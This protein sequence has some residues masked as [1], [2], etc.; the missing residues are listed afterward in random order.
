LQQLTVE[1]RQ[2]TGVTTIVVTHN[3]EEAAFLGQ[4][5]LVLGRAPITQARAIENPAAGAPAYR[6]QQSARLRPAYWAKCAELREALTS[7]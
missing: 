6:N 3:I 1:L 7:G 5:I 2:E 4:R